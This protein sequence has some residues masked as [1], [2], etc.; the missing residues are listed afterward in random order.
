MKR[1]PRPDPWPPT[2]RPAHQQSLTD[3]GAAPLR[4]ELAPDADT[5]LRTAR[6]YVD[7]DRPEP[8]SPLVPPDFQLPFYWNTIDYLIATAVVTH[9]VHEDILL[10]PR[11]VLDVTA[12][13]PILHTS[14]RGT[15][16]TVILDLDE[17]FSCLRL[18]S[19]PIWIGELDPDKN[20]RGIDAALVLLQQV[21]AH[22]NQLLDDLDTV[23]TTHAEDTPERPND[24]PT[25]RR[26]ALRRL[27]RRFTSHRNI[28]RIGD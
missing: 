21:T 19:R 16:F 6:Q 9:A 26:P 14:H 28:S 15:Y 8:D 4:C 27:A 3:T 11:H 23:I 2:S 25:D 13:A 7:H 10:R 17:R 24:A 20:L 12:S 18:T 1:S 22:G 5:Q